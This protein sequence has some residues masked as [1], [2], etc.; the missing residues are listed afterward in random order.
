MFGFLAPL[1]MATP[2]Q[3]CSADD[4]VGVV[5]TETYDVACVYHSK[6]ILRV[7]DPQGLH[8]DDIPAPT[9]AGARKCVLPVMKKAVYEQIMTHRNP[10]TAR[11]RGRSY[12]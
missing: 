1:L 11:T 7:E 8:V 12:L 2:A 3:E 9:D 6:V 4:A 10:P 5:I